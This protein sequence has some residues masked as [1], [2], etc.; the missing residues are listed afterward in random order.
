MS[1]THALALDVVKQRA[2]ARLATYVARYPQLDLPGHYRWTSERTV[3]GSYRG[4]TGT[5]TLGDAKV[6]IALDLPFFARPFRARIESFIER[7][8]DAIIAPA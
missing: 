8:L 3:D 4:G 7:E 5:I 6:I 1:R 2:E